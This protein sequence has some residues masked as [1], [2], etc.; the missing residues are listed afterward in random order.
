MCVTFFHFPEGDGAGDRSKF[1]QISSIDC[2]Q[3]EIR[4]DVTDPFALGLLVKIARVAAGRLRLCKRVFEK[5]LFTHAR[6]EGR[7]RDFW[8]DLDHAPGGKEF[9]E[10]LGPSISDGFLWPVTLYQQSQKDC[11]A[12]SLEPLVAV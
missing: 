12:R 10:D 3:D 11:H 7:D 4:S 9:E 6:D 5:L 1:V 2:A 8:P